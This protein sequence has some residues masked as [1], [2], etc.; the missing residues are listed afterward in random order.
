M[1]IIFIQI[2]LYLRYHHT[3]I[4][5]VTLHRKKKCAEVIISVD[6]FY[7]AQ[8]NRMHVDDSWRTVGRKLDYTKRKKKELAKV[9]RHPLKDISS[10]L[11][12]CLWQYS[13]CLLFLLLN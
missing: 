8:N 11:K 3:T 4:N 5:S 10:L 6:F 2:H 9:K 12:K 13:T 1:F 7:F